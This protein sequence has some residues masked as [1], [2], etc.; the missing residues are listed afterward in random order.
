MRPGR[1]VLPARSMVSS[2]GVDSTW[3]GPGSAHTAAMRSSCT[4]RVAL[5]SAGLPVPSIIVAPTRS[6]TRAIVT[7][8]ERDV[9]ELHHISGNDLVAVLGRHVSEHTFDVLGRVRI[10]TRRMREIRS[11]HDGVYANF[12]PQLCG[13]RVV[14]DP[15]KDILFKVATRWFL[16]Q[17]IK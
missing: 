2:A 12:S 8:L 5:R 3:V 7:P 15:G 6:N 10:R 9:V 4:L 16:L 11:P 13:Q 14:D 1:I 17:I